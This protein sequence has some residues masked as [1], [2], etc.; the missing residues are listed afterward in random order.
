VREVEEERHVTVDREWLAERREAIR[1]AG[2]D[3]RPS[4]I[5]YGV[6]DISFP[7]FG[8]DKDV[9][10]ALTIPFLSLIDGSQKV[11]MDAARDMLC[12]TTERIS[13]RL[14]YQP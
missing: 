9:V 11:E 10:A 5:T 4:P 2:F 6:T 14:G 8:F 13:D 12:R 7:I 3:S 1:L